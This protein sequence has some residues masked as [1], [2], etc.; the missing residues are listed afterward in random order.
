MYYW[1]T[2]NYIEAFMIAAE[3]DRREAPRPEKRAS[4]PERR[5]EKPP[6]RTAAF[7]GACGFGL[8]G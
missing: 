5:E 8:P 2:K 6:A 1:L 4:P 7:P 3:S